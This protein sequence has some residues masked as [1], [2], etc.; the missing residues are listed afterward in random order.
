M[1]LVDDSKGVPAKPHHWLVRATMYLVTAGMGVA[2][3]ALIVFSFVNGSAPAGQ[4]WIPL[5]VG[6]LISVTMI[7]FGIRIAVWVRNEHRRWLL[8]RER[9]VPA[10][11]EILSMGSAPTAMRPASRSL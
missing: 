10:S 9:G 5:V 4:S 6:I 1:G 11:A 2:G 3:P 8:L 7:P